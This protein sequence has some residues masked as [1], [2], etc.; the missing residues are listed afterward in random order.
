MS[1]C[2]SFLLHFVCPSSPTLPNL[3][4]GNSTFGVGRCLLQQS[5]E[6]KSRLAISQSID[7]MLHAAINFFL[8]RQKAV[9][10]VQVASNPINKKLGNQVDP[11]ITL[12]IV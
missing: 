7:D 1:Y 9:S 11:L 4:W 5:S 12:Y 6:Q 2:P 10:S 8:Q 3:L